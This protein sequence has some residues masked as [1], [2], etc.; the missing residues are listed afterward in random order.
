[1]NISEAF[2][3]IASSHPERLPGSG[4][5]QAVYDLVKEETAEWEYKATTIKSPIFSFS[6]SV[7]V[8]I[9]ISLLAIGLSFL[10]SFGGLIIETLLFL[11]F[12][13]E[14]VHPTLAKIKRGIAKNL[15]LTIPARSKE[16]QRLIITTSMVT[17][18]FN[19]K[20]SFLINRVY[21]S[22]IYGLGLII[23]LSLAGNAWLRT[24]GLL[25]I[26][27]F[28]VAVIIVLKLLAKDEHHSA[29]L[30]NSSI[31]LELG[32]ILLKARP[33]TVSVSLYF[34][35]ANSLNSG[36][37]EIPHILK[38]GRKS[39]YVVNLAEYPDKRINLVTTDGLVFPQQS[40]PSLVEMLME[41]SKEK[42]IP[43]QSI[44]FSEISPA[45]ALK[46]KKMKAI[47]LTNPAETPEASKNIRELL[48]GLIRKI[49]N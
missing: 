38:Q 40:D 37:L 41:V 29:G 2:Q 26:A 3:E 20:P 31:L 28:S 44:K 12:V 22:I 21:L 43:L 49:D 32:T 35:G 14:L 15:V 47:S 25:Y 45:Y 24:P 27:L 6:I 8:Y 17:D 9:V 36:V 5:A 30:T 16:N 33:N 23:L 19:A 11:L 10:H 7:M 34:S 39:G 13:I 1:M 48:S 18:N 46:L 42:A 4:G